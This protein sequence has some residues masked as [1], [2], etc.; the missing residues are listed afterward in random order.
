MDLRAIPRAAVG[1]YLKAIRWPIDR[2]TVLLRGETSTTVD[3]AEAVARGVAGFALGD[4]E[5]QR[6]AALRSHAADERNRASRLEHAADATADVADEKLDQREDEARRR[7]EQAEQR[8]KR[9]RRS[10][11]ETR[12]SKERAA[13]QAEARRK[14]AAERAKTQRDEVIESQAKR[15]RLAALEAE[16]EALDR[17]KV[18][19]TA[20]DEAQRLEAAAGEAKEERKSS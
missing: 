16:K 3:R 20:A 6:D 19:V 9:Q 7:R 18:A 1:G 4:A 8:A 2:A 11:E 17:E 13:Q 5:L 12:R 15:E 14:Q 10:A